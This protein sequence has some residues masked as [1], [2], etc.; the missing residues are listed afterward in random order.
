MN[1]H[2]NVANLQLLLV[3]YLVLF[4]VLTMGT[5]F[6][7]RPSV[8]LP[9]CYAFAL[10]ITH[11][12][13][14]MIYAVPSY[15]PSSAILKQAGNNLNTTFAGFNLTVEGFFGLV[16]G[17]FAATAFLGQGTSLQLR[18]MT[19]AVR[20]RMPRFL[21]SLSFLFFFIFAPILRAVPSLGSM[22]NAGTGLSVIAAAL[23]CWKAWV[24]RD[25]KLLLWWVVGSTIAFPATTLLFMGFMG[26]GVG[27]AT[28]LWLFVFSFY[29]P[30]WQ[31]VMLLVLC[32][33]GGLS[34]YINYMVSRGAIRRSV[35]GDQ[36]M[37]SR[38]DAVR[39]M[40]LNFEFFNLKNNDHLELI[41]VRMNQNHLVGTCVNYMERSGME[42]EHGKTLAVAAVAWVPRLLWPGKPVTGGSGGIVAKHTGM[43][44][45]EG[46]SVGV[47]QIM[48]F[49]INF[50]HLGVVIGLGVM[51]F[52]LRWFDLRAAQHLMAGDYWSFARWFLP[53]MGMLQAGGNAAEIVGTTAAGGV[54]VYFVHSIYFKEYYVLARAK[55]GEDPQPANTL[56]VSKAPSFRV[57]K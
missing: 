48:E 43:S 52:L 21:L 54:F 29:R 46:T 47:G 22:G 17:W 38:V 39:R 23:G 14:A 50:G 32:C 41:D 40:F 6:S 16:L 45:G 36:A 31:S 30:R 20:E 34:L 8:G 11:F 24:R 37:S 1:L 35:W 49:F 51:G 28:I 12:F 27:A 33:Y 19:P 56:P 13:G 44:F 2:P 26:Y 18:R 42:F 4:A 9:L 57:R 7:K 15:S 3:I 53:A 10:T 25:T 5:W 55:K